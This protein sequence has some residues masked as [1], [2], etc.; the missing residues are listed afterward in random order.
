MGV[1]KLGV[2]EELVL[3]DPTTGS[4]APRSHEVVGEH[5]ERIGRSRRATDDL[6]QE[7]L[8]HQVETMT[9]AAAD[10]EELRRQVVAARRTAGEA[11]AAHGLAV[12]A[13][14]TVPLTGPVSRVTPDE[15]YR[16][17]M[18]RF[19]DVAR[20]AGTCGMHVHVD[21]EDD[22]EGVAVIDRVGLWLPLLLAVSAN[23]PYAEG[24]DTGYASWRAQVW[25]RW[26]TAGA[27]S[28]FGSAERYHD[29]VERLIEMGA[30]RDPGNVYFDVRLAAEQPTVE[31]RVADVCTDVDDTVLVAVLARALVET[32][33]QEARTD[34]AFEA[35][36]VEYKRGAFWRAS[37]YGLEGDLVHPHTL[38]PAPVREIADLALEWLGPALEDAG[39]LDWVRRRL[40]EQAPRGAALQRAVERERGGVRPVVDDLVARTEATWRS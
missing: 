36:R 27:T 6:S 25:S 38:R 23:S 22:D 28:S 16:D 40:R 1:R 3:V 11:A 13:C 17:L 26:P 21:V 34:R 31:V 2:E 20:A 24:R 32:V 33:A 5:T 9:D 12:V 4:A 14:G 29:V 18:A 8:L 10:R 39:D 19:G 30:A 7:L 15:R 35:P 37:R